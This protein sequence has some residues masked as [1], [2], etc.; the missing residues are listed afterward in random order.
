MFSF[1]SGKVFIY[2]FECI[3]IVS[4]F[5]FFSLFPVLPLLFLLPILPFSFLSFFTSFSLHSPHYHHPFLFSHP[6]SHISPIPFAFVYPTFS[7]SSPESET[8]TYYW[9][10]WW[11]STTVDW[12]G[13]WRWRSWEGRCSKLLWSRRWECARGWGRGRG[14]SWLFGTR[15]PRPRRPSDPVWRVLGQVRL[16]FFSE[17]FVITLSS[18]YIFVNVCLSVCS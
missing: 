6:T 4:V 14:R 9:K 16:D 18:S 3:I 2:L 13:S 10:V 1:C 17:K 12:D 5:L 15:H 8:N 7:C 11:V